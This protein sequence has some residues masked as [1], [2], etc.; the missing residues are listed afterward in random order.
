MRKF[1]LLVPFDKASLLAVLRN[2]GALQ[3][4]EYT[5]GGIKAEVVAE[6][7]MWHMIEQ[8]QTNF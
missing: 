5:A 6:E 4:E 2:A 1:S 7:S 8:Y 3:S